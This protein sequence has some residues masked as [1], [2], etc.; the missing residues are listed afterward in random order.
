MFKQC[1][2]CKTQ[3]KD[4]LEENFNW[5][6]DDSYA[7]CRDCYLEMLGDCIR[8]D[9]DDLPELIDEKL[10]TEFNYEA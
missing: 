1:K 6:E 2:F 5:R 10:Q 9:T 7:I 4:M 8:K 3:V